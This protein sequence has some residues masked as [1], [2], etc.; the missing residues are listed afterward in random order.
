MQTGAECTHRPPQAYAGP[1]AAVG[2]AVLC[3]GGPVMTLPSGL[4]H[5]LERLRDCHLEQRW[6]SLFHSLITSVCVKET[7]DRLSF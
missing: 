6:P 5:T 2:V 1:G 7:N 3:G 4:L